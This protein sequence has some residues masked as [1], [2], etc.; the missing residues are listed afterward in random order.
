MPAQVLLFE[1]NLE[2]LT[3]NGCFIHQTTFGLCKNGHAI[4]KGSISGCTG[5]NSNGRSLCVQL[6]ISLF[7]VFQCGRVL[8]EY[9]LAVCLTTPLETDAQLGQ[10]HDAGYRIIFKKNALAACAANTKAGF[11]DRWN[12]NKSD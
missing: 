6:V 8:K 7:E 4:N 12:D 11:A 3:T 9:E 5:C 2:F 1:L 10:C